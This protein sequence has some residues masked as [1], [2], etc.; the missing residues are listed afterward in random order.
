MGEQVWDPWEALRRRADITLRWAWLPS[1]HEGTVDQTGDGWLIV[2]GARLDRVARRCVLAHELVHVER[3]IIV[4]PRLSMVR[5]EAIV[6]REVARRLV[7]CDEL[8]QTVRRLDS[9]G[10][11]VEPRHVAEFYDVTRSVAQ[12][13]LR[14]LRRTQP[15]GQALSGP[16]DA[17]QAA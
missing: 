2:L 12:E 11:G 9:V 17:V 13:A 5:E 10:V 4:G 1:G 16:E 7:P 3:E 14:V 6:R 15:T 8:A